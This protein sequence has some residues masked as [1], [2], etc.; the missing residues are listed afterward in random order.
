MLA[1]IIDAAGPG[2]TIM[3]VSDHG[4]ENLDRDKVIHLGVPFDG[5]HS[6]KVR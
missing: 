6:L 1:R 4:W 3:L 5:K 2:A